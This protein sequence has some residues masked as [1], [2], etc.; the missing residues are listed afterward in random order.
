[1]QEE[2]MKILDMIASGKI[3]AQEGATLLEALGGGAARK[4]APPWEWLHHHPHHGS[5]PRG[6]WGEKGRLLRFK[7]TDSTTDKTLVNLSLPIGILKWREKIGKFPQKFKNIF[8]FDVENIDENIEGKI[9]EAID[10]NLKKKI[11]VWV[12]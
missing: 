6:E 10:E 8:F 4:T 1:M 11:E 2:Q 5:G 3:T 9:A 7:V 12:E